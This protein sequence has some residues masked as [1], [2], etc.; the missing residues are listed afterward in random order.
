VSAKSIS[1]ECTRMPLAP[2]PRTTGPDAFPACSTKRN[3]SSLAAGLIES[4]FFLPSQPGL[5]RSFLWYR[6][7]LCHCR[8]RMA[9]KACLGPKSHFFPIK[10]EAG[11]LPAKAVV[12]P[13]QAGSTTASQQP[14]D[15]QQ[16]ALAHRV[17][18]ARRLL[19]REQH[20]SHGRTERRS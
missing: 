8:F 12:L 2:G 20:S 7:G 13:S 11:S 3:A 1:T 9:I 5:L 10:A 16:Q 18:E 14:W 15:S 4:S 6:R 19:E 17:P